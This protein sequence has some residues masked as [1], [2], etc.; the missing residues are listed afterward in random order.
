MI[1]LEAEGVSTKASSPNHSIL[2]ELHTKDLN[3]FHDLFDRFQ[4]KK[5]EI[6]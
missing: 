6:E 5:L 1:S 2:D 4:D 3:T